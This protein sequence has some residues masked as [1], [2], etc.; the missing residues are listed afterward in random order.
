[1]TPYTWNFQ[2]FGFVFTV[3]VNRIVL[4]NIVLRFGPT[5]GVER[6]NSRS[7]DQRSTISW[8][9]PAAVK[10]ALLKKN[11]QRQQQQKIYTG[12]SAMNTIFHRLHSWSKKGC[13]WILNIILVMGDINSGEMTVIMTLLLRPLREKTTKNEKVVK[14]S[15]WK[16]VKR[17]H[18]VWLRPILRCL[19]WI[20]N[21]DK[22][23]GY[24]PWSLK[25]SNKRTGYQCVYTTFGSLRIFASCR[26][27]VRLNI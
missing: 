26:A 2:Y 9:K 24:H 25:G 10:K 21:Q 19:F 7:M 13:T 1:M 16:H 15:C 12:K 3:L 18:I 6:T 11:L 5:P 17:I 27:F 4:V 20:T 22:F 14:T 8:T 23:N